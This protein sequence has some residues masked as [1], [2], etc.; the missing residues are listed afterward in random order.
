[1]DAVYFHLAM[2][3]FPVIASIFGLVILGYGVM[4]RNDPLTSTGLVIM[5]VTGL[6][7]IPVYL[8]GE[9]AE[10]VVEGLP[11][12]IETFIESHE[13]FAKFALTSAIV[14]GAVSLV[15]LL[16]SRARFEST[17][18]RVLVWASLFLTIMTVGTMGWTA[19]LGG[20]IR[21]TEIRAAA[22]QTSPAAAENKRKDDDDDDH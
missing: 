17:V 14:S 16:F 2:N 8:T 5:I 9:P 3:H 18:G 12:V 20:V 10:E 11:G 6:V 7:A 19:K 1:M 4:R 22:D 13:D 15:A 21:H